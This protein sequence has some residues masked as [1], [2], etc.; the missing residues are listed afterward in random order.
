MAYMKKFPEKF[1]IHEHKIARNPYLGLPPNAG[2]DPSTNEGLVRSG[3]VGGGNS[4]EPETVEALKK[5]WADVCE[6]VLG[7]KDYE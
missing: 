6:P 4:L 1:D 7:F 2:M 3:T 5:K